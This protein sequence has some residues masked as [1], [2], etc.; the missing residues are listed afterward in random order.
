[1]ATFG[2][3]TFVGTLTFDVGSVT[4]RAG[5]AGED[6]PRTI[7]PSS[8]CAWVDDAG[9]RRKE[10]LEYEPRFSDD[11]FARMQARPLQTRAGVVDEWALRALLDH[12]L[13]QLGC[14]SWAEHPVMLTE[15]TSAGPSVR[16]RTAEFMFEEL[17]VPALCV[18]RCA[19]LVAISL[20]TTTAVVLELGGEASTAAVVAD[21]SVVTRSVQRSPL[22]GVNIAR[23]L[24]QLVSRRP[25]LGSTGLLP[26][27]ALRPRCD[28]TYREM[29]EHE[30]ARGLLESVGRCLESR[31]ASAQMRKS[32]KADTA[33]LPPAEYVLPDGRILELSQEGATVAEHL[34]KEHPVDVGLLTPLPAL[35]MNAIGSV[36]GEMHKELLRH[37]ILTGGLTCMPG[38][39]ERLEDELRAAAAKSATQSIVNQAHRMTLMN[40]NAH[41]RR[42]GAW[43]GGSVLGSLGSHTEIWMSRAEYEEHGSPLISRKGMQYNW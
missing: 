20:G 8:V 27:C 15:P 6:S 16:Q 34:F 13:H 3:S 4:T 26:A 32:G 42:H 25:E 7:Y 11:T 31:Q 24:L 9:G 5:C 2:G 41:D 21:G 10:V 17:G 1:M 22:G 29:R 18:A 12:G 19:E 14:T 38:M 37:V 28:A 36:E 40:A 30:F 23:T 39:N 35:V 33:R 43:L